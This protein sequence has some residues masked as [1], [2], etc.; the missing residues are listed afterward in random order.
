MSIKGTMKH[1]KEVVK[2]SSQFLNNTFI[3]AFSDL[4]MYPKSVS[5]ADSLD[6]KL[7]CMISSN[8]GLIEKAT[9]LYLGFH[10]KPRKHTMVFALASTL[11]WTTRYHRVGLKE[12]LK[13]DLILCALCTSIAN[14][15]QVKLI[16]KSKYN[17]L[18][19]SKF[20]TSL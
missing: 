3:G 9:G 7:R 16:I 13:T 8:G 10:P 18:I 17:E 14:D 12:G 20:V 6:C 15:P 2:E 4:S 1:L 5:K 11:N 19:K